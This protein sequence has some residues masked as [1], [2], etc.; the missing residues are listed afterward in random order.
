MRRKVHRGDDEADINIT[1]MLDIVFIMLIF[2]IVTTSFVKEKGLEVSRR[3]A[4]EVGVV[5]ELLVRC[6][7]AVDV[8]LTHRR[9]SRERELGRDR[10]CAYSRN[11]SDASRQFAE[12][13]PSIGLVRTIQLEIEGHHVD[14]F[15]C[16]L[17]A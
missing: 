12:Q 9:T 14:A 17:D 15:R 5:A 2:F 1:P 4:I 16:Q 7:H 13:N 3:N 11:V 8:D 10:R 6:F